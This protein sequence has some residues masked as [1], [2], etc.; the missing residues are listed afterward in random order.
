MLLRLA[1][2]TDGLLVAVRSENGKADFLLSRLSY[3]NAQFGVSFDDTC[4]L[5][6]MLALYH[7]DTQRDARRRLLSNSSGYSAILGVSFVQVCR[8]GKSEKTQ[9]LRLRHH[10]LGPPCVP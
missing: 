4:Y 2:C 7:Q 6:D 3:Y 8:T 1:L 10:R 5:T 9:R